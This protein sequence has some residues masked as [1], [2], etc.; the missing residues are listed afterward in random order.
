MM[1]SAP[2]WFYLV[3]G[4]FLFWIWGVSYDLYGVFAKIKGY[5]H[6]IG[7]VYEEGGSWHRYSKETLL[8]ANLSDILLLSLFVLI[9]FY[10][11][12]KKKLNFFVSLFFF[13]LIDIAVR[14]NGNF[15]KQVLF[16]HNP[17]FYFLTNLFN[18]YFN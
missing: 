18:Q 7:W 16:L 6:F 10:Y 8:L 2:I 3:N 11:L 13:I 9:N 5:E 17:K 4:V 15:I 1:K 12:A 14:F